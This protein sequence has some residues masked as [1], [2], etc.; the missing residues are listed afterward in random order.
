MKSIIF[1][2]SVV[3]VLSSCGAGTKPKHINVGDNEMVIING[4]TLGVV[5]ETHVV[6]SCER[7]TPRNVHDEMNP[8]FTVSLEDGTS[9]RSTNSYDVGD[10][11]IY[12]I[13]NKGK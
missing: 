3:L 5:Y 11:I 13:Y 10:T 12:T 6:R 7:A 2:L 1:I 8:G 4:D 9:F